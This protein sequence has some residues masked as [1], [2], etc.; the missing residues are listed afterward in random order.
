MIKETILKPIPIRLSQEC[1]ELLE[2][3]KYRKGRSASKA[4]IIRELCEEN[5]PGIVLKMKEEEIFEREDPVR[6]NLDQMKKKA[7]KHRKI[8]EDYHPRN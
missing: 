2:Y 3:I 4:G 5:L 6:Y 8:L 1:H 7:L